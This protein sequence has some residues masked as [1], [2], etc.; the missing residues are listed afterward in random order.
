MVD[1]SG[2]D[3]YLV[4]QPWKL[5]NTGEVTRNSI[6]SE[7]GLEYKAVKTSENSLS[8]LFQIKLSNKLASQLSWI[9]EHQVR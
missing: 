4:K 2:L 6:D 1:R 3:R 9:G 7:D 8:Y 5:W